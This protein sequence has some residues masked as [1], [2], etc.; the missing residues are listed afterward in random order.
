MNLKEFEELT[1]NVKKEN[2]RWFGL[3]SDAIPTVEVIE[4]AEKNYNIKFP[5]SYKEFLL[6]HGGGYFAFAVV[7]SMD[8]QSPFYIQNNV[9]V[10]F[11]WDKNFLPVIDFETGDMAGFRV[12]EGMC[13]EMVALYNHEESTI[14]DLNLNFFEALV[15]Y[16]FKMK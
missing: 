15:R 13:D 1:Q 6:Q 16:G 8:G 4:L 14:T 2:P 5:S 10:E 7:Y 3:D 11:V 9:E 12:S